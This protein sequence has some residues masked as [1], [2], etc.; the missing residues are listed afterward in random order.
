MVTR[1]KLQMNEMERG[2][3]CDRAWV[4]KDLSHMTT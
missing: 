3:R 2:E 1:M 4:G